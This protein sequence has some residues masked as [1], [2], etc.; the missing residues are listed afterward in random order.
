MFV[1]GNCGVSCD[2]S[3]PALNF[4][5]F[6]RSKQTAKV[7]P[8]IDGFT[9]NFSDVGSKFNLWSNSVKCSSQKISCNLLMLVA[10]V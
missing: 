4:A 1:L 2:L 3:Y 10:I 7:N 9:P 5:I 8:S 6:F